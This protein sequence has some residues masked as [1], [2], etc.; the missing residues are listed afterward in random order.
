MRLHPRLLALGAHGTIV[1]VF[2]QGIAVA[3]IFWG[4]WR[5]PFG[6][7]VIRCAFMPCVLGVLLFVAGAAYLADSAATLL[8]PA[9]APALAQVAPFLEAGGLPIIFWLVFWGVRAGEP[10]ASH[11]KPA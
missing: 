11:A 10:T 1:L 5:L 8:A 7:L 4:L 6:V 3:G 9:Y 2:G